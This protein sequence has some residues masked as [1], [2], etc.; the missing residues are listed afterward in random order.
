MELQGANAMHAKK[1]FQTQYKNSGATPQTKQ[2][3]VKMS[4]NDSSIR[5][6]SRVLDVSINT[7]LT[8]LKKT[9]KYQTNIN[10]KYANL[11]RS[12]TIRL[13]MDEM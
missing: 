9:Q 6:I 4:L 12:L 3:I 11:T 2:L 7:V 5:D 1:T 8:V 13:E 10:P